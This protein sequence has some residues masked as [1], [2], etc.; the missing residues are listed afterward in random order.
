MGHARS[1]ISRGCFALGADG[2]DCDPQPV[3]APRAARPRPVH[4]LLQQGNEALLDKF[5]AR[6]HASKGRGREGCQP[7]AGRR[8]GVCRGQHGRGSRRATRSGR[9]M[10][11]VRVTRRSWE[12]LFEAPRRRRGWGGGDGEEGDEEK[13]G[14]PRTCSRAAARWPAHHP[15]RSTHLGREGRGKRI[16]QSLSEDMSGTASSGMSA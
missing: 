3:V 13:G 16:A 10:R 15:P 5:L 6:A 7:G 8:R 4:H 2:D 12:G 1:A 14:E 9:A 11:S